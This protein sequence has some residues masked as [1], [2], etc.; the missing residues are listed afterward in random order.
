MTKKKSISAFVL[1]LGAGFPSVGDYLQTETGLVR[2]I[3]AGSRIESSAAGNVCTGY[4]LEPA[5]Y[6]E[7]DEADVFRGRVIEND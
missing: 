2:V 7:C 5:E 3:R 1:E 4:R 6:E